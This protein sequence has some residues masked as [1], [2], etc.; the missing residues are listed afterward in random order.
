MLNLTNGSRIVTAAAG[1]STITS[2]GSLV[3]ILGTN[4][5]ED[6]VQDHRD[7]CLLVT[8]LNQRDTNGDGFGNICDADLDG[9][10][11]VG[12]SDFIRFRS[13]FGSTDPD[14]DFDGDGR[15]GFSDF[16]IFR[17]MF[18]SAPGPSGITN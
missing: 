14:A 17:S 13:A 16:I 12:F 3:T 7:N 9:D 1:G 11:Q 4:S 6:V 2:P 8:N 18:G 15:V 10:L 5:D